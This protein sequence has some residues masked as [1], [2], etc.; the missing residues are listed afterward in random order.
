MIVTRADP[1]LRLGRLR[2]SG[3][4]AEIRA[5]DLSFTSDE[6]DGPPRRRGRAACPRTRSS[7]LM[8]RTEGWPAGLYLATLSLA[9]R[10]DPDEFVRSFSGGNRFVGDY[11]TEEVLGRHTEQERSFITTISILDRF[12]A[13]LCDHVAG[14]TGSAT[15]L[16]DLERTNLFLVPLDE[17]RD[18]VP[19]PP[20]V[21]RR[22]PQRAR[23]HPCR[24][25]C[26]GSTPGP[27]TG[28]ATTGTSTR[29]SGTRSRPATPTARPPWSRPTG[30]SYVDAG[31]DRH[32][33]RVARRDRGTTGRGPTRPPTSRRRGWPRSP[34]TR[35]PS[36][37]LTALLR[38]A[39]GLRPAARRQP[40]GG[41]RARHDPG[42]L[43]LRRPGRHV[44]GRA[45]GRGPRDRQPLTVLR[46]G[47]H[48]PRPRRLRRAATWTRRS[49][50]SRGRRAT[51][52]RPRSS[53]R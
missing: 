53:G 15:L 19:V 44:G 11:L 28:S 34:A 47:Q 29:R 45:A 8:E 3:G 51:T 36:T 23:D 30:C 50:C 26:P 42:T 14:V 37:T 21:R 20:P 6:A 10:D 12:S 31:R 41:V 5:D 48:G 33:A 35:R 49:R 25:T 16:R 7:A 22:R 4:L 43:R 24:T 32:R 52:V 27:P 9:G 1:G 17:N 39:P 13:S 46:H 2:A 18:L 38:G 40:L